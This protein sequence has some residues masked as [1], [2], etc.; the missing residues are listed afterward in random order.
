MN[1]AWANFNRTAPDLKAAQ[2][3]A[4]A[5]LAIVPCWH[6]VKDILLPQIQMSHNAAQKK[7]PRTDP[8]SLVGFSLGAGY[9]GRG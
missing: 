1:R 9:T 3:D 7:A 5:A 2:Q 6:Y 4:E 8:R